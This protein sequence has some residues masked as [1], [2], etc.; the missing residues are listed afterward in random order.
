MSM[1][2]RSEQELVRFG[3][4]SKLREQGYP[5]P[6]DV[7]VN[8]K[9][10]VVL[11]SEVQDPATAPRY[12]IAGRLVQIRN[13]GKA[14]FVHVLDGSGKIQL[15]VKKDVLGDAA[16][17]AFK[18]FDIGDIV[19]ASGYAFVTKTGEK[20]LHVEAIRLLTKAL[21]PLPE[22]WHGLRDQEIRYRARYVDLIANPEVR[23]IFKARAKIIREV[24]SFLDNR[25]YVEVETPVLHYTA[26]GAT[27]RPFTTYHNALSTSMH[28]R[29]ALELPLKKLVVG[30]L[31][32]VY[33]VGRV[34]RNEGLSKK[35]NPEFTMLEFYQAYATF[36]DLM[37]L[38]EDMFVH[39]AQAVVGSLKVPYGDH[40]LDFTPPWPRISMLD[41]IYSVGGVSKEFDLQT[42]SGVVAA[43][44]KHQ[45]H[46]DEPQDWGRSLEAL[47]GELVEGKLI[48]PTFITHHPFSISPLARKNLSDPKITDRFELIIAGMEAANAF[49]ELNDAEDQR[50]RF[51]AQAA[52]KAQGD[53]EATD[54]DEDFL[55]ALEY[56]LPPTAGEG[57]GIDRLVMLLTNSSTIRDVVLFPQLKPRV[58]GEEETAQTEEAAASAK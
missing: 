53:E 55:R 56:G 12:T 17:E 14:A 48:N 54:V 15:Y 2:D 22:K 11:A 24:R 50:E 6:N 8:A 26:G 29:I 46:L 19:E 5:F 28:L 35:H 1:S 47:W 20:S 38:T 30:G 13:M 18:D 58:E 39:L 44:K 41:S 31:E 3:K 4:L 36:E 51:E 9:A 7:K 33:E 49:S 23:D 43:A 32:R 37:T 21:I 45:V 16:F 27:A 10:A 42:L 40:V 34:F 57:V 25:D 52:R